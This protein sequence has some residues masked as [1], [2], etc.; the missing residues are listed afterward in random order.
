MKKLI[1]LMALMC[2]CTLPLAACGSD[3]G[4]D[5]DSTF[6]TNEIESLPDDLDDVDNEDEMPGVYTEPLTNA[7]I[8]FS[9]MLEYKTDNYGQYGTG[10]LFTD[11]DG[12]PTFSLYIMVDEIYADRIDDAYEKLGFSSDFD[13]STLLA[14]TGNYLNVFTKSEFFE[15]T[16]YTYDWVC[17]LTDG[18]VLHVTLTSEQSDPAMLAQAIGIDFNGATGEL[19]LA[20]IYDRP[21][22]EDSSPVA[23]IW[24]NAENDYWF[25]CS[26]GLLFSIYD[27][28]G[29]LIDCGT[30][31]SF[32]ETLNGQNDQSYGVWQEDGSVI[33]DG[34]D[35]VFQP[36]QTLDVIP[37]DIPGGIPCE[38]TPAEGASGKV[39]EYRGEWENDTT[40]CSLEINRG[41]INIY[42]GSSYSSNS[43]TVTD[44]GAL[45]LSDG[46]MIRI[47]DDGGLIMDGYSGVFYRA[48]EMENAYAPYLGQ[49]FNDETR[50]SIWLQDGGGYAYSSGESGF[51]ASVW[52]VTDIGTLNIGGDAAYIDGDGNLV[53]EGQ[54]GVFVM[55]AA[56]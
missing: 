20:S 29:L 33:I 25:D 52:S 5:Y 36:E 34:F 26:G 3:Y 37:G 53:I 9:D 32:W 22:Y 55:Q 45:E 11:T 10:V 35:G 1:V 27:G 41:G 17:L 6:D 43:Y 2:V 44:E 21:P 13:E 39:S 51:G 18:S 31:D 19:G 4:S 38:G 30:Y 40:S 56:S 42:T 14:Y 8:T 28:E 49:W 24:K 47:Q 23:G 15:S 46:T 7:V 54:D 50:Q 48:G 12:Y 16:T